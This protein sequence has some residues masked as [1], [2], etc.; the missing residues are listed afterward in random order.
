MSQEA[1][2]EMQGGMIDGS[3]STIFVSKLLLLRCGSYKNIIFKPAEGYHGAGPIFYSKNNSVVH[4]NISVVG[5]SGSGCKVISDADGH[6]SFK[7]IGMCRYNANGDIKRTTL[8]EDANLAVASHLYVKDASAFNIGDFVWVGDGKFKIEMIDKN[9]ITL[10]RGGLPNFISPKVYNGGRDNCLAGQFVTLDADDKNGIRI[11][12]GVESWSIDT[13]GATIECINNAWFGLFNYSKSYAGTQIIENIKSAFNGY[14]G[15]GLGYL[16]SGRVMNCH[17]E[18]NGNNGIDI[19][20]GKPEVTI[21]DNVSIGNGVDGIFIGGNGVTSKV[22]D[23]IVSD[24]RRIGILINSRINSI[25]NVIVSGNEITSSGMNAITLT[26]VGS[27][28]IKNNTI[29]GSRLR[30]AIFL[31]EKKGLVIEGV[32]NI[33]NNKISE[34]KKG[35]VSSNYRGYAKRNNSAQVRLENNHTPDP[36]EVTGII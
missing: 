9:K 21:S 17:S 13:S 27:G 10:E 26:G 18:G 3:G 34:T 25:S 16:N 29:R 7:A 15:I 33:D 1:I 2:N 19:F 8:I 12:T 30:A 6:H 32:I 20:E 14:C 4:E 36:L 11:G 23:N 35:D 31:E 22:L 5:F 28:L 24:N